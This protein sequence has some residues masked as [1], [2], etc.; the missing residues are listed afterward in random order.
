MKREKREITSWK[1]SNG[2]YARKHADGFWYMH[3]KT[4]PERYWSSGFAKLKDLI[5]VKTEKGYL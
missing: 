2:S 4:F 5:R 1:L 3:L